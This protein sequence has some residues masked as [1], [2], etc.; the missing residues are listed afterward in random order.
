PLITMKPVRLLG[1]GISDIRPAQQQASLFEKDN[2]R[3]RVVAAADA[4]NDMWGERTVEPA[5]TAG[6][7]LKRHVSGFHH[8]LPVQVRRTGFH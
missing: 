8:A 4:A 6:T 7:V 2:K 3:R 5:A 1:I